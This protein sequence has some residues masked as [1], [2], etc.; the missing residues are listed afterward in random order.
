MLAGLTGRQPRCL[1]ACLACPQ[2]G[3]PLMAAVA[4]YV[5][6]RVQPGPGCSEAFSLRGLAMLL[7][8]YAALEQ[9]PGDALLEAVSARF[10][11]ALRH[12]GSGGSSGSS[13]GGQHSAAA[14]TAAAGAQDGGAASGGDGSAGEDGS[15]ALGLRSVANVAYCFARFRWED[16]A[17]FQTVVDALPALTAGLTTTAPAAEHAARPA[18]AGAAAAGAAAGAAAEGESPAAVRGEEPHAIASLA[19][20][21]AKLRVAAAPR[22]LHGLLAPAQDHLPAFSVAEVC[23]LW[24]ALATVGCGSVPPPLALLDAAAARLAADAAACDARLLCLAV[25]AA[26]ELRYRLPS[27]VLDVCVRQVAAAGEAVPASLLCKLLWGCAHVGH[28]P[29]PELLE[30]LTEDL[31]HRLSH[32]RGAKTVRQGGGLLKAGWPGDAGIAKAGAAGRQGK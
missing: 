27:P 13:A 23:Q 12:L 28:A 14:A 16:E 10:T 17:F 11:A 9:H 25:Y 2:D 18:A 5:L 3:T 6:A 7:W 24:W 1:P 29:D 30:D 15:D 4:S 21:A 8:S 20:A 32:A 22:L 26:A 19:Y 31:Y